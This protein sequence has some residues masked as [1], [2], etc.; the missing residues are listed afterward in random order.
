MI[1]IT[2]VNQGELVTVKKITGSDA[3]R[4]HLAERS[5]ETLFYRFTERRL[6]SM[7][8]WQDELW[9]SMAIDG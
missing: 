9:Y 5:T 2:L 1:P 7:N 6:H 8:Q 3:I 4:Q